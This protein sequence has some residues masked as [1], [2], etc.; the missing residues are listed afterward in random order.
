MKQDE[1]QCQKILLIIFVLYQGQKKS[2]GSN[3]LLLYFGNFKLNKLSN[4]QQYFYVTQ[5]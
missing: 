2:Q 4:L 1:I 5:L 3:I